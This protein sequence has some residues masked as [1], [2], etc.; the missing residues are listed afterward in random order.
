MAVV[1]SREIDGKKLTLAP[2]GWTYGLDVFSS[3]FVLVDKETISLWFLAGEQGCA[4]P[5]EPA[6][7]SGCGLVGI[8]GVY[9]DEIL[10]GEFLSATTW[11]E[12]GKTY[13]NTKFVTE[14]HS[15]LSTKYIV[16]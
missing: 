2:S 9:S 11:S 10:N 12:W 4:L 5:I 13:P 1:Y 3:I 7:E 14:W 16:K 8:S 15:H 6:G